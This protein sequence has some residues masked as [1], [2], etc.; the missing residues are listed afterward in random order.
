MNDQEVQKLMD[1]LREWGDAT[2]GDRQ[3]PIGI[4]AHL[5]REAKE[6]H[7]AILRSDSVNDWMELA[8]CFILLL[9]VASHLGVDVNKL[10][11]LAR[12]KLEVNKRRKWGKP[13]ADGSVQ[14]IEA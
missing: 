7:E 6:L 2:F 13:E 8:D 10:V 14:H 9:E 3:N 11:W 12:K 4:A 1:E 5:V